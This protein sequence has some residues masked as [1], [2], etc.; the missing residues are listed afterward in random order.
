MAVKQWAQ[1]ADRE[2]HGATIPK[3][4]ASARD[5]RRRSTGNVNR[6]GGFYC[7]DH[8]FRVYDGWELGGSAAMAGACS[9]SVY[10]FVAK[11]ATATSTQ[12]T[13]YI[14]RNSVAVRLLKIRRNSP[15]GIAASRAGTSSLPNV[16]PSADKRLGF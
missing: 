9:G 2:N 15:A 5:V 3:E 7:R 12:A 4:G 13:V 14:E 16:P 8:F 11:T 1:M 6:H 10:Y